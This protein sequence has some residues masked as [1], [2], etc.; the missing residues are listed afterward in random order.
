MPS[1]YFMGLG[2][3]NVFSGSGLPKMVIKFRGYNTW[4]M[5]GHH[6]FKIYFLLVCFLLPYKTLFMNCKLEYTSTHQPDSP[7]ANY[8]PA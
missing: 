6:F 8:S 2:P 5:T 7:N 4:M 1:Q 3:P